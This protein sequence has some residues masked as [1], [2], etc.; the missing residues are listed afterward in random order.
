MK[1]PSLDDESLRTRTTPPNPKLLHVKML[2]GLD[3]LGGVGNV[4][5]RYQAVWALV[6]VEQ[7]PGVEEVGWLR[8]RDDLQ[9][10]SEERSG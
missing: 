8:R 6:R 7:R 3:R 9:V 5:A 10:M 2:C 4:L 1:S